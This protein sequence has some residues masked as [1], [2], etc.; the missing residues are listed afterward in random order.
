MAAITIVHLKDE[1]TTEIENQELHILTQKV[2]KKIPAD[3]YAYINDEPGEL[4]FKIDESMERIEIEIKG[5]EKEIEQQLL[6]AVK[7]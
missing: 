2:L 5:F 7:S 6:K 3:L 1:P 4:I